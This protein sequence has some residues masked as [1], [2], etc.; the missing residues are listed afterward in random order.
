MR[1]LLLTLLAFSCSFAYAATGVWPS[2]IATA[3]TSVIT[4]SQAL[5]NSPFE[6]WQLVASPDM[7]APIMAYGHALTISIADAVDAVT[8]LAHSN[9]EYQLISDQQTPKKRF[10]YLREMHDGLPVISGRIDLVYG[11]SDRLSRWNLREHSA[12]PILD[13]HL[14]SVS[15]AAA[16]L[17]ALVD[18]ATWSV[19]QEQSFAAW[20]P[21]HETKALRPVFWIRIEGT[22][23]HERHEGIV[24]AV[25]G[26][27]ILDWPGICTDVVSGTVSG[28]Y[29]PEYM[30]EEP[31]FGAHAYQTVT[32][33]GNQ[34]N[35]AID[36]TFSLEGGQNANFRT[37][38]RGPYVQVLNDDIPNDNNQAAIE[39]NLQ[40][41]YAPL[42]V[43]WT[44]EIA[45]RPELNLY[46]HTM[47][48][49]MWYKDLDPEF[50]ELDY[51][52]PAVA[53]YDH[54]YDNAFWNGYG[55]YYGEGAQ[56]NN[57][58]MYS[59]IIYH[60][61]THGVTSG[62]YPP[63]MLPY[64]GQSGS[65]NEAWSDYFACTIN[66][67]P[68]SADWIGGS[69]DGFRDLESNL[70]YEGEDHEVHVDSPIISA[71]LWSIRTALGA[72]YADSLAHFARYALAETYL[73]YLIAVLEM[74]DDDNDLTNGTPNDRLIYGAFGRHGVGPGSE[75][76]FVIR[77]LEYHADGTGNSV[78]NGN[79]YI[80]QGEVVELS[81]T[82][83]NDVILYP[84]PATD[85]NISVTTD[86][87]DISINNGIAGVAELGP[88]QTHDIESVL[89]TIGENAPDHWTV[90]TI[91][92]T[93]NSGMVVHQESFDFSIGTPHM[94]IVQDD[95]SSEVEQ[96]VVETAHSQNRLF[97]AIELGYNESLPDGYLP[98]S[99]L[100]IWISGNESGAIL[101]PADQLKLQNFIEAGNKLVL[102]GQYLANGLIGTDFL[103]NT[104][105]AEVL[106]EPTTT[107]RVMTTGAPFL[108]DSWF[109][110]AGTGGAGNQMSMAML[111]PL[112]NST[113]IGRYGEVTGSPAIIEFADGDGMLL[114]F[115]IEAISNTTILGNIDRAAFMTAIY[116][117]AADSA[118][119]SA[120]QPTV[121]MPATWSL[122]PAYP[123][124]FNPST[125]IPYAIPTIM[126]ARYQI[127]DLLGR[128]V[129]SGLLN[130][131][132]GTIYWE[133]SG[134]SGL[135]FLTVSCESGT[136]PTQKLMLLK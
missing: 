69:V 1:T 8:T 82:V 3:H 7:D 66:N 110:L 48:I 91:T 109:L 95:A 40:A 16:A 133:H 130:Q 24:D 60:E 52:L 55:T 120:I 97:E 74:D 38:L 76:H 20:Y 14:L 57:F 93:S 81:F 83:V 37:R 2:S 54:A 6:G 114:G 85:V 136:L 18:Y 112:G 124:P 58:A 62:I 56:Y 73:D 26:E 119:V 28:S 127:V 47:F 19:N 25:T 17:S 77:D 22:R 39:M 51:P 80:E 34:T 92:V 105:E 70:V 68:I 135:Y 49:W 129:D 43:T 125:Q 10:V 122:G 65:M 71:P 89:L 78:G 99:G 96:F 72:P 107:R 100:V 98:D 30:H 123:N 84:P 29:W 35:T 128:V 31:Q 115:G 23:P 61:Y 113:T 33:N 102:S 59:D 75:P 126:N 4:H 116:A 36:G 21:D 32:V 27:I 11:A 111:N 131:Q 106:P 108:P 118:L 104:I 53:N 117:W 63:G 101:T 45:T 67:D 134:P 90:V 5:D 132:N 15:S 41:P 103:Q 50:T 94:L 87:P 64:T 46:Y 121:T 42:A 12:W 13:R 9:S 79:R 44:E 88:A 86:D